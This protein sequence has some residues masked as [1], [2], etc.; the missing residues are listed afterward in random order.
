MLK[1]NVGIIYVIVPW[2]LLAEDEVSVYGAL[3]SGA[4]KLR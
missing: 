1:T 3:F 4:K 2:T